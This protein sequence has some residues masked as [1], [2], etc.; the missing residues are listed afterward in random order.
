M[1]TDED[2]DD[3]RP[4]FNKKQIINPQDTV[5]DAFSKDLTRFAEEGKIDL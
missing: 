4:S 2:D 5:L 3:E 1:S